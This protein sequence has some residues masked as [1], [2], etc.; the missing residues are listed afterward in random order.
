MVNIYLDEQQG[1]VWGGLLHASW[2]NLLYVPSLVPAQ[3]GLF[4]HQN[5]PVVS[6]LTYKHWNLI[7]LSSDLSGFSSQMHKIFPIGILANAFF[8]FVFIIF[9]YDPVS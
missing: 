4:A 6:C 2:Q 3:N 8:K 7:S 9:S 1:D 5:Y